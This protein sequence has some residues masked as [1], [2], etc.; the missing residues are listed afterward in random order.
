MALGGWTT[1][2]MFRRY[3]VIDT[4][5]LENA[6]SRTAARRAHGIDLQ[7]IRNRS[8]GDK[9]GGGGSA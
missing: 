4:Q 1:M 5:D 8:V 9:R 3:N 6:V 2:E 7:H